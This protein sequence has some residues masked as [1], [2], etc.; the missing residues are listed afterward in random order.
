VIAVF[1]E[2]GMPI[3]RDPLPVA[4]KPRISDIAVIAGYD[5]SEVAA[6]GAYG[7]NCIRV[8]NDVPLRP[9]TASPMS[10][11]KLN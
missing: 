8:T 5:R 11:A 2:I 3:S 10:F 7:A 9:V 6:R 1:S 4:Q